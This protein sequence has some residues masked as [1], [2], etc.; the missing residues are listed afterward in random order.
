MK[1]KYYTPKHDM[2]ESI[3]KDGIH[4]RRFSQL[5]V[6]ILSLPFLI[7]GY[8]VLFYLFIG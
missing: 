6:F 7:I 2:K 3:P 1:D 4:S 5:L 8:I